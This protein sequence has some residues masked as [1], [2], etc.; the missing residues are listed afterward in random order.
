MMFL[1]LYTFAR[2]L[3]PR[4]SRIGMV[5]RP[6]SAAT[7]TRPSQSSATAA[8]FPRLLRLP[9][10]QSVPSHADSNSRRSSS[11]ISNL[12]KHRSSISASVLVSSPSVGSSAGPSTS[13]PGIVKPNPSPKSAPV[14]TASVSNTASSSTSTSARSVLKPQPQ[15]FRTQ[16]IL[17]Q[18]KQDLTSSNTSAS[19]QTRLLEIASN[20][21][22]ERIRP[23]VFARLSE[24]T[25]DCDAY[26]QMCAMSIDGFRLEIQPRPK[27]PTEIPVRLRES[28]GMSSMFPIRVKITVEGRLSPTARPD[29][30]PVSASIAVS[31]VETLRLCNG[32]NVGSA[33]R[34]SVDADKQ[35]TTINI[36]RQNPVSLLARHSTP[37]GTTGQQASATTDA[38]FGM[39]QQNTTLAGSEHLPVDLADNTDLPSKGDAALNKSSSHAAA[40]DAVQKDPEPPLAVGIAA[41]DA[42]ADSSDCYIDDTRSDLN[43]CINASGHTHC[44]NSG[45]C[46]P[47]QQRAE[48]ADASKSD[49][50]SVA[51]ECTEEANSFLGAGE[52][53]FP[54]SVDDTNFPTSS[55]QNLPAADCTEVTCGL[56]ADD[57]NFPSSPSLSVPIACP[58][59]LRI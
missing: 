9:V 4:E 59:D 16:M 48:D 8:A 36:P 7:K 14:S 57:G 2:F 23:K 22:W 40:N 45:N 56:Q 50:N 19:G 46:T 54:L 25:K 6:R 27:K 47:L 24:L 29:S 51:A 41:E 49:G 38:D 39:N 44:D 52:R 35:G 26:P 31:S 58:L 3:L 21:V 20:C 30:L 43:S 12:L 28:L 53:N 17:F 15:P 55:A 18:Q 42:D 37:K 13:A 1:M 11:F 33:C 5:G 32:L 10:P 34:L